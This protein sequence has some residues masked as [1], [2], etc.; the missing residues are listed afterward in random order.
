MGDCVDGH[1]RFWVGLL[2]HAPGERL[3]KHHQVPRWEGEAEN[4]ELI[5]IW[6]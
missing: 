6:V 4:R 2:M 3:W 1:G 5:G